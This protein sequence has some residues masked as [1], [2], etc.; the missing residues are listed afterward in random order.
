MLLTTFCWATNI[1]A[2]KEALRG[3][4]PLALAQLRVLG[5]AVVFA[6]LFL[7]WRRRPSLRLAPTQWRSLAIVAL[8]GITLNQL[9][10]I[11]GLARTSTAHA[12]LIVALGPV[13]VLF[14]SCFL[15]MEPLTWLK[16]A[17]MLVSF[18]GVALLTGGKAGQEG[19]T[20]GLGDLML[21]VGSAMFAYYTILTKKVADQYDTLTLNLI[22]FALGA[23]LMT[24]FTA[25]EILGTRWDALPARVWCSAGYMI[26]LGSAAAYL[27]FAFVLTEL[28]PSRVAAFNYLQP[29]IAIALGVWMLGEKIT[30]RVALGGIAILLGVYLAEREREEVR[31]RNL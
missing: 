29:V 12:A 9:C 18:C 25:H 20:T 4:G 1:I 6:I 21:V 22:V 27:I 15:R 19:G 28:A 31:I 23:L 17:G 7:G 2:G 26:V 8:L 14:L 10:F 3:V 24:P 11:G 13:M 16:S 5:A 30:A